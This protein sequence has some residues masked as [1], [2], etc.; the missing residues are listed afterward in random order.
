M[1]MKKIACL[2]IVVLFTSCAS[3]YK[4]TISSGPLL[5]ANDK[6]IDMATGYATATYF[7]GIGG[8]SKTALV[9]EAK[10]DMMN[11]RPLKKG[12]YYSNFT[13]DFRKTV[14]F[15]IYIT[16]EVYVHAD[17]LTT[18][19]DS[20]APAI[21]TS[22]FKN[23]EN[24]T[25][26]IN[27]VKTKQD[28]FYVGEKVIHY[29]TSEELNKFRPYE[30]VS[31]TDKGKVNLKKLSINELI[32]SIDKER[33]GFSYG[34]SVSYKST[35]L[36]STKQVSGKVVATSKDQLMVLEGKN[37]VELKYAEVSKINKAK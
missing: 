35:K 10:L 31:F 33:N 6:Y 4:G 5:S 9:Y 26:V 25:S 20:E 36:F 34:D 29:Y 7:F 30:I 1:M 16:N 15:F 27:Y 21:N 17:V 11:S 19:P 18:S 2:L 37:T 8:L 22:K 13:V 28:S 3:L 14:A 23:I 12:E 32:F 24:E